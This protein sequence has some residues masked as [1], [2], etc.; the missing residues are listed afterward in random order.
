MVVPDTAYAAILVNQK[1]VNPQGSPADIGHG[2]NVT[3]SSGGLQNCRLHRVGV[4]VNS[5]LG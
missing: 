4:G 1:D 3:K 5:K 2:H